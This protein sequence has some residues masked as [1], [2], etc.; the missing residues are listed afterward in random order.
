MEII[1]F[2]IEANID[3]CKYLMRLEIFVAINVIINVLI[4]DVDEV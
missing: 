3:I 2:Q 1:T 4:K